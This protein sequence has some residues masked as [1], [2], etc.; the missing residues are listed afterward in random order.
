MRREDTCDVVLPQTDFS[1]SPITALKGSS[2]A[3]STYPVK[4]SGAGRHQ[5]LHLRALSIPNHLG[6]RFPF[7]R[8]ERL[9]EFD[10]VQVAWNRLQPEIESLRIGSR[11]Q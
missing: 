8:G 4:S 5:V 9:F 11:F 10:L 6:L 2:L 7:R 3:H 1:L